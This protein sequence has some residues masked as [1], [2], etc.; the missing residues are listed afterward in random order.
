MQLLLDERAR[1]RWWDRKL[2]VL[3]LDLAVAVA[4][5]VFCLHDATVARGD[6]LTA[7]IAIAAIAATL[8]FAVRRRFPWVPIAALFGLALISPQIATSDV[9]LYT[10]ARQ[11]GPRLPTWIATALVT[12]LNVVN[13][14]PSLDAG[15]LADMLV[16]VAVYVTATVL[17][18]LW[19]FQRG[20][21]LNAMRERADQAE[22]EQQLLTER[23]VTAERR[24]VAR[25]MHDVVAH[26]LSVVSLQA[27]ALTTAARDERTTDT[28]ETIR[29]TGS[30]ALAELR[31]MLR[32]LRDDD[33]SGQERAPAEHGESADAPALGAIEPLVR[34][35]VGTGADVRL[36]MPATLP[37][38]S[39]DVGRAAYRVVQESLT[40]A[41]KHAPRAPV[42]VELVVDDEQLVVVVS[43]EAAVM[44][45]EAADDEHA[46]VPGSGYGLVG[47]RERI[48]LVGGSL[49][50]GPKGDGGYRVRATLPAHAENSG[51]EHVRRT[52]DARG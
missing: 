44:P 43:N 13:V 9:A 32:V 29:Q 7:P 27:G 35:A 34:D 11:R 17:L 41:A 2:G 8:A 1:L 23:A 31:D 30:T 28:A 51:A 22:R 12:G 18:G 38:T 42:H 15:Q 4:I 20:V 52:E 24:R 47:M 33:G 16:T 39:D 14:S 48:S 26:R 10:M 45:N 6:P 25:E 36:D 49:H 21:L 3:L 50:A 37:E 40:N 46:A 5:G 19:V